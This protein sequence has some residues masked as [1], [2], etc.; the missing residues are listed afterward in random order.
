MKPVSAP[1]Y[2]YR[3]WSAARR[4]A[5]STAA[6]M[7]L[8][9]II[10]PKVD[11]RAERLETK[12]RLDAALRSEVWT[13]AASQAAWDAYRAKRLLIAKQKLEAKKRSAAPLVALAYPYITKARDDHADILAINDIVPKFIAGDIRGDICQEIM[14]AVLEGRT[15][16]DEL[17]S[18]RDNAT[19]FIKKFYHDN[20]EQAGRAVSFDR[21]ED[22]RTY[23]EIASSIAAKEWHWNEVETRGRYAEQLRTHSPATQI[24]DLYEKQIDDLHRSFDGRLSREEVEELANPSTEGAG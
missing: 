21:R 15:T 6:K 5:A 20:Y 9:G 8:S 12:A 18:R 23:D 17:R 1:D 10:V 7:R 14:L 11:L 4:A 16:I 24:S 2:V 3:P 19:F 22:E 13:P